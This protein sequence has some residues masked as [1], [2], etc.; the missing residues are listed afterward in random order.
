MTGNLAP[1][2]VDLL[3]Q[4]LG[5]PTRRALIGQLVKGPRSVSDLARFLDV[6]KTAV[7]QHLT[8]LERCRLAQSRKVGR[9]RVCS[10]EPAG[11]AVLQD[12]VAYHRQEW[13]ARLDRLGRL[14]EE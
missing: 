5:D 7:G 9:V 14:L 4:A 3:F 12:W 13:D 11:L 1:S 6:T 8:L 10:F 2:Q